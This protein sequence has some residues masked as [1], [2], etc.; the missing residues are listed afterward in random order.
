LGDILIVLGQFVESVFVKLFFLFLVVLDLDEADQ[1]YYDVL[2][3]LDRLLL[4]HQ[5]LV[6]DFQL[7][8]DLFGRPFLG[9]IFKALLALA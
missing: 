6:L 1:G 4:F 2:Q 3:R 8:L 5:I 9:Y 7:I